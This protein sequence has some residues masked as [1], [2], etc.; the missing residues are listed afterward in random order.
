[1]NKASITKL[2]KE[3]GEYPG[4]IDEVHRQIVEVDTDALEQR[5]SEL[6]HQLGELSAQE[7]DSLS[8]EGTG[9]KEQ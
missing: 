8:E 9:S 1:M 6:N 3:I 4:R 7:E 2:N 5:K